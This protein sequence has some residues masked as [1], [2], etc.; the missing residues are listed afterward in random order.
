[1]F[2]KLASNKFIILILTIAVV[3]GSGHALQTIIPMSIL[4]IIFAIISIIPIVFTIYK[5]NWGDHLIA[6]IIFLVMIAFQIVLGFG[7]SILNYLSQM[8]IIFV[9]MGVV[10]LYSF[11]SVVKYYLK[12]MTF[13]TAVSIIGYI[14]AN[15]GNILQLPIM[16]NVNDVKYGVGVIFNYIIGIP[17][18][19]CGMFWEPGLFATYLVIAIVFELCFKNEKVSKP[20][21][22]LFVV[23]LITANSSAGFVLL[24]LCL[25]LA[26]FKS[27]DKSK[28]IGG[29]L[30]SFIVL[31]CGILVLSNADY[32][33]ENTFLN[34]SEYFIKLLSSNVEDSS[35]IN[36][37]IHNL[38]ILFEHPLGAGISYVS[39][40]MRYTADTSTSTYIL[41][42]Y[43]W[44]G[45]F[46]T[47]YWVYS[48]FKIKNL[49][50]F[51]KIALLAIFLII[52]N[53]EPHHTLVFTWCLLFF[54][55][56]HNSKKKEELCI[57]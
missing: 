51:S 31:L 11:E 23:G 42:I 53:K 26:L 2:K 5:S 56:K 38:E 43:G 13:V 49:N 4:N 39:A 28:G 1:M 6:F 3:L 17:E 16:T 44:L 33:I 40:N 36:A 30:V 52:L 19:N 55:L 12:I 35:R 21:I 57:V 46:Y 24:F 45:V 37:I 18:R 20:R 14:L 27:N 9:A 15:T 22:V 32:I 54:L 7:S 50:F 41:S 48:I 10:V 29:V 34:E 8:C 47:V 25:I